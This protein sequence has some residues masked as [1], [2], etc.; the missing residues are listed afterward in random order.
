MKKL[1]FAV[2]ALALAALP[3]GNGLASGTA[4]RSVA[5]VHVKKGCHVW[6]VGTKRSADV[7]LVIAR[8]STVTVLNH[9]LD[10][11]RLVQVAGPKIKTGPFMGMHEKVVLRFTEAG[12]FIFHTRAADMRGMPATET[13]GPDNKLVLTIHAS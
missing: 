3:G 8:G 12:H 10:M 6:S 13:I 5:I 7:R 9:D 11:H 2:I 4:T 1:L